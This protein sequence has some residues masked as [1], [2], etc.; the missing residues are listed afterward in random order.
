MATARQALEY[1][2]P[3]TDAY[4]VD[5][6]SFDDRHYR[7]LGGQGLRPILDTIHAAARHGR[8]ARDRHAAH[9]GDSTTAMTN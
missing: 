6:K 3:W 2:Q 7:E 4:K 9:P 1:L 5:L 8:L